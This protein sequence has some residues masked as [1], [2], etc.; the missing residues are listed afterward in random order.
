MTIT[1]KNKKTYKGEGVY[2]GRPSLLG[3]PFTH[4]EGTTAQVVVPSREEAVEQ[5]RVWLREQ[6][7]KGGKV[8]DELI[9][10][11]GVYK[12]T[13][14]LTLVCWCAPEAC[15]GHVLAEI[16]PKVAERIT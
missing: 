10:L 4:K 15:H 5:Y 11:A 6:W 8:K 16:I 14:E 2:I 7:A 1:V 13:G 12:R 3:N 9:R